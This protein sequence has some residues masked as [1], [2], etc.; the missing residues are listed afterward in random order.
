MLKYLRLTLPLTGLAALVATGCLLMSGQFLITYDFASHGYDPVIMNSPLAVA[1]VLVDLKD[2]AAFRDNRKNLKDITDLAVV[3]TIANLDSSAPV[4]ISVWL[5]PKPEHGDSSIVTSDATVRA[6][7]KMVWGPL[8]LAASESKDV[9]WN[10]SSQLFTNKQF[11]MDQARGD[12]RFALYALGSN[13][14]HARISHAAIIA[15]IA[16]SK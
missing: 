11:V 1:G 7:G 14:Y 3:G 6:T 16:G 2:F 15:V 13:G 10:T 9:D 4:D 12:A 5:V 8:H